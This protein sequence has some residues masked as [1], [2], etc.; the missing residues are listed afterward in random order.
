VK[1]TKTKLRRL[2]KE[3]ISSQSSETG[4]LK[5]VEDAIMTFLSDREALKDP[6][7]R[8]AYTLLGWMDEND[9][10]AFGREDAISHLRQ[11]DHKSLRELERRAIKDG[12]EF[13]GL[14]ED[15]HGLYLN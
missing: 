11:W 8:D 13:L 1:L 12:V 14:A 9:H 3:E 7:K 15:K 5:L 2:I 10:G 6:D 4:A